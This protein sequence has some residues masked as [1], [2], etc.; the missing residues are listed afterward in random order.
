M[1]LVL[2][3]FHVLR[4]LRSIHVLSGIETG[5]QNLQCYFLLCERVSFLSMVI[6]LFFLVSEWLVGDG[7]VGGRG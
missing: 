6:G 7:S 4:L 2:F 1:S 3:L 5:T